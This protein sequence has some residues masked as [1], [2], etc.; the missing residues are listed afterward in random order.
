MTKSRGQ[1]LWQ[2]AVKVI[3]G[4][5]GLLSKRPDR[6]LP[7]IWPVY[8]SKAKGVKIWD[9]D[10]NEYTDM[11][12]MGIGT[13]IL[14]YSNNNVDNKVIDSI[15]KG[16][17][18]TLNCP[19]EVYLAQKILSID[20]F[21]D[22]VKFA[23]TGGEA[24]SIAIRIAR[25]RTGKDKV[26]F[27]G[28]HGWSDWY[29]ASNLES[30]ENLNGHLLPGLD[31]AG[32]PKALLG[33]AIP[34]KYNDINDFMSQT[35]GEDLAAII[36]EGARYDLADPDFLKAV[37]KVASDKKAILI[38]DEISS[39]WR[40]CLGGVYHTYDNFTPDIV[41]YGKALGNGYAISAVVGK[42]N[43][44]N[45]AETTFISSTFWTERVGFVA[46]LETINQLEEKCVSDHI[47]RIGQYISDAW[48]EIFKEFEIDAQ[49]TEYLPLISFKMNYGEKN[50]QIITFITQEMLKNGYLAC[51]SIYLSYAH[52][53]KIVDN[54][55]H[56]FRKVIYNLSRLLKSSTLEVFLV[57][58]AKEEGFARLT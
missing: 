50:S 3:P 53:Q 16:I 13:A 6:Y 52:T 31:P 51:A 14:G 35:K 17:N 43:V 27:S 32:V 38:I 34:F 41:V 44:M 30:S 24:M 10:N 29:L 37:R 58:R 47:N 49:V 57:S 20:T 42:K 1:E 25:A 15:S 23:R 46:A 33:T 28:Y 36:I 19:E 21:A 26:A 22:S 55:L 18:T 7:D 5:N 2:E 11:A 45:A 40:S 54:Y 56:E 9:L 12:Q 4:G 39:G 48:K 8:Y